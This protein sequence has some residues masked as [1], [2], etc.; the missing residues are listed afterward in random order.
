MK[1][2]SDHTL[3]MKYM[4]IIESKCFISILCGKINYWQTDISRGLEQIPPTLNSVGHQFWNNG[5][6]VK[7][8]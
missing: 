2:E 1:Y 8:V 4:Y 6:C 7:L 3:Q 5:T